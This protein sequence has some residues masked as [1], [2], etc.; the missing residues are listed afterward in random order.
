MCRNGAYEDGAHILLRCELYRESRQTMFNELRETWPAE[1]WTTFNRQNDKRQTNI[2]TGAMWEL[3]DEIT[4]GT[5]DRIVKKA[6]AD[7]D[8]MRTSLRMP[9]LRGALEPPPEF[10]LEQ[11]IQMLDNFDDPTNYDSHREESNMEQAIQRLDNS[12]DSAEDD[13]NEDSAEDDRN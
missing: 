11:A 8:F 1:I 7:M 6:M 12:E 5:T 3:T 2:L 9:S 13:R 10:S 4:L